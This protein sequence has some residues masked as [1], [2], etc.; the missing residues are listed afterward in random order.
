[1]LIRGAEVWQQG[2]ADVRIAGERIAAVGRLDANDG[3]P[4]IE[5]QGG[6]LLP[7]LH[8]HHIHLAALA[9]KAASVACGPPEVSDEAALAKALARPGEGW[10]RGIGYHE[11]VAGMLDTAMLDG[12][13]P[14]RPVRIQ[15]RSGRMWF[16]NSLAIDELLR[17]AAP[18]PGFDRTTGRLFDEDPWLRETL[19]SIPPRFET[20]SAQLA[21]MGVTGLTDMTPA[22]D[23][24]TVAHF[25]TE[26]AAGRLVQKTV[27][28]GSLML[29]GADFDPCLMLGP[30]K[31]HLHE[32]AFPD[33]DATIAFARAAHEQGRGVAVH[34]TTEA[35][36]V[37]ALTVLDAGGPMRGD[38]IEH[39]GIAPD[40]LVAEIARMGLWAVSQPHFIAER[41]DRYARDVEPRDL[42]ALY[43]LRA[44]TDAGVTLAAGSDAPFGGADPWAS[45]AAAV[46][47]TTRDGPMLG[48][49]EA[50]TPEAALGLFLAD[51]HDLTCE[52]RIQPGAPADLCL[53]DRDWAAARIRLS[54]A[55][56]RL[57]M[58]DGNIVH[59]RVDQA[60]G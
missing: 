31:L 50:L 22:N 13:V 24:A 32:A 35:E 1:M 54:A 44:F 7:G 9:A 4:V 26:Q 37:F 16:L 46:S 40:T 6:A 57:T 20:V 49:A 29:A 25:R 21:A 43:R 60:P 14:H 36:L 27:L 55:D 23:I 30:A 53:L 34:C 33:L 59:D 42:P 18:P 28:A 2:I 52:R 11:S 41:G 45:M 15:H 47:R 19:V 10:M 38:R 58:I 3:E 51:P 12:L 56:V 8:D 48:A 17:R 5:A 39:A